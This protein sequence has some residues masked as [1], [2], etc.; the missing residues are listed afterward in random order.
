MAP[1]NEVV[2]IP[3]AITA[4]RSDLDD[5]ASK[6]Q[7]DKEIDPRIRVAVDIESVFDAD[8]ILLR[9]EVA[10]DTKRVQN[11]EIRLALA[12]VRAAR[13]AFRD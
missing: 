8:P 1:R 6:H 7:P 12:P 4:L 9:N 3:L 2:I 5:A 10:E 13:S 11:T